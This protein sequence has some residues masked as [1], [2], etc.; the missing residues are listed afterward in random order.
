MITSGCT[1][2]RPQ[3]KTGLS[4]GLSESYDIYF[5]E[6]DLSEVP[7]GDALRPVSISF[8]T[9]DTQDWENL[10]VQMIQETASALIN[11]LLNGPEDESLSCKSPIPAGTSLLELKLD[12]SQAIVDLSAP[13]RTLSG[14]AL[15]LADYAITLTLTQ[16]PEITSVTITVRGERLTYRENQTFTAQDVLFSSNEDVIGTV[17]VTLYFPDENGTLIAQ[18]QV[19]DL[20]EGDTQV[21]AVSRALLDGPKPKDVLSALPEDFQVK[22]VWLEDDICYV[23]LPSELDMNHQKTALSALTRSLC[24]LS[25]VEEVRF[26]IDGVF[27]EIDL[28]N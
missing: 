23:N 11:A 24:S 26:L 20:Y 7:G 9:Q 22:S 28:L 17:P 18:E 1:G 25:T 21:V 14:V 4:A 19:L 10:E 3:E 16:I 12:G 15:T 8:D 5:L 2:Q 13:Y 6:E 27:Q